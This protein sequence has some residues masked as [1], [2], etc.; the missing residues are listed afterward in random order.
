M[1]AEI[2]APKRA[3]FSGGIVTIKAGTGEGQQTFSIH[4]DVIKE[5]SPFFRAALDKKWKE[6]QARAVE[7]PEDSPEVVAAYVD[8]C[9]SKEIMCKKAGSSN[10][11]T[12]LDIHREQWILAELYVFGEKVQ[13]DSFC[14]SVMTALT[15]ACELE[16]NEPLD[17]QFGYCFLPEDGIVSLIYDGIP[18]NS[19]ARRF[20]VDMYVSYATKEWFSPSTP[21]LKNPEFLKDLVV[22]N[23]KDSPLQQSVEAE[24]RSRRKEWFKQKS[25]D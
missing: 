24:V 16:V 7:L 8:W 11:Y 18:P 14:D 12:R 19:P 6:G 9:Y 23:L 21:W 20:V 4:E 25:D 1:A 22:A 15:E 10:E 17:E 13:D 5:N 2:R 3:R